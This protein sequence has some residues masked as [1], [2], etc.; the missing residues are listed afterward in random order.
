MTEK[1][2]CECLCRCDFLCVLWLKVSKRKRQK[3]NMLYGNSKILHGPSARED[4]R[5]WCLWLPNIINNLCAFTPSCWVWLTMSLRRCTGIR[6]ACVFMN[7]KYTAFSPTIIKR[8]FIICSCTSSPDKVRTATVGAHEV[9]IKWHN[10]KLPYCA[11]VFMSPSAM[12][13]KDKM[14]ACHFKITYIWSPSE[15]LTSFLSGQFIIT[16][17][18]GCFYAVFQLFIAPWGMKPGV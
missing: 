16:D 8:I 15:H 13:Y 3:T 18:L 1:G 2:V 6:I 5:A 10:S 7:T 11:T 4:P 12:Q 9:N 14:F 17:Q